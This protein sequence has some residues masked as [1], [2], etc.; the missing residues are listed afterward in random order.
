MKIIDL[1]CDALLKLWESRG[2][3]SFKNSPEIDSN[4]E[5]LKKG[6][7]AAQAFAV[8]IDPAIKTEHKFQ[9][10]LEQID[11]FYREILENNDDI[12]QI[13]AWDDYHKLKDGEIGAMLTLEGVDC[14]GNDLTKLHIL[15]Q[16]GV[17][18]IGLTWNEANLAADGAGETRGAGLTAFGREIVRFNNEKRLLTDVSHLSE[19]AFW[20][21]MELARYPI[22]S[23]SNAKKICHHPRNLSDEQAKAMFQKGGLVHVV[24]CPDFV[25]NKG[26]ATISDLIMHIDHLCTLGGV[27]QLGLG[28]DFDGISSKVVGLSDASES[29]NLINE[30]LRYFSE[31]EVRGFAHQNFLNYCA[32]IKEGGCS[33]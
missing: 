32:N 27:K 15:Y 29:Q 6:E 18:S 33:Y 11:L 2:K 21:V 16:L 17:R 26:A 31:E 24:Y 30:L 25:K 3:A 28:S 8:W 23:H 9:A 10:A 20:E 12:K 14:I 19:K 4:K 13:K 22:A 5:R 7:V 1:H